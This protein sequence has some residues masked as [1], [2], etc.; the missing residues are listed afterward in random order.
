MVSSSGVMGS[1]L[2]VEACPCCVPPSHAGSGLRVEIDELLHSASSGEDSDNSGARACIGISA[3]GHSVIEGL[4]HAGVDFRPCRRASK[5]ARGS[6]SF[7]WR[8]PSARCGNT[9]LGS[10]GSWVGPKRGRWNPPKTGLAHGK[11]CRLPLP[12]QIAQFLAVP[13]H[14][15]PH[16]FQNPNSTQRWKAL[17]V[18]LSPPSSQRRRVHWQPMRTRNM[19]PFKMRLG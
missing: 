14:H 5:P 13:D 2:P 18:V 8:S 11:V 6:S 12:V 17:C 10:A 9:R 7:R 1:E 3:C 4:H 19:M 16:A 15:G